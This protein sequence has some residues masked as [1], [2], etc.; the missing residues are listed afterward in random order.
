MFVSPRPCL[1]GNPFATPAVSPMRPTMKWKYA[2]RPPTRTR[3]AA[4]PRRAQFQSLRLPGPRA[5]FRLSMERQR[6]QGHGGGGIHRMRGP[7]RWHGRRHRHY[8]RTSTCRPCLRMRVAA[9]TARYPAIPLFGW[10]PVCICSGFCYLLGWGRGKDLVM[11]SPPSRFLSSI[12]RLRCRWRRW[13]VLAGSRYSTHRVSLFA[14]DC[15]PRRG[16]LV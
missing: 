3:S 10:G 7:R 15:R 12:A 11:S 14:R 6:P 2:R 4:A 16:Q 5:H 13:T 9:K 1:R 8:L